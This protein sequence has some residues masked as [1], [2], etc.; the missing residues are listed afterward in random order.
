MSAY[1]LMTPNAFANRFRPQFPMQPTP[2]GP[3]GFTPPNMPVQ[4]PPPGMWG[5]QP[6]L[7]I[8]PV[9]A[10]RFNPVAPAAPTP[11][12]S[13]GFTPPGM[14]APPAVGTP[15]YPEGPNSMAKNFMPPLAGRF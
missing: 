3:G 12:G 14:Q 11:F 6:P 9:E 8:P 7:A 10:G 15:A 5:G 4:G 2:F 13:G 1:P